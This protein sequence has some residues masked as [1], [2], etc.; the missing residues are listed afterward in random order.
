MTLYEE[1][2]KAFRSGDVGRT[3]KVAEEEGR[4]L[5]LAEALA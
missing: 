5:S 3:R 1:A 4:K 2:S